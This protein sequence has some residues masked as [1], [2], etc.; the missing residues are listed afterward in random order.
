[1][2]AAVSRYYVRLSVVDRPG[3][4]AQIAAILGRAN[5]SIASVIQPEGHE[6]E[7]VPLI[8]MIHEAPGAAMT[9]ALARIAK[10]AVVKAPP[11]MFRVESL[12]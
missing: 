9:K 10:L 6:G 12:T 3:V 4:L 8:F 7:R 2:A 1:M 5:I 11:V